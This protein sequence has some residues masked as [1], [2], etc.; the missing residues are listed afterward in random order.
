V[1]I[2]HAVVGVRKTLAN[3]SITTNVKFSVSRHQQPLT[4]Q[5]VGVEIAGFEL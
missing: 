2:F 1:L 5:V 3:A 4:L